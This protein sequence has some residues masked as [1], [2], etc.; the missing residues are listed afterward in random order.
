MK[1][2]RLLVCAV[3]FVMASAS[4]VIGQTSQGRILGTV[5][6][7][8]GAVVSS[9]IVTVTNTATGVSRKST[10]S[11]AGDFVVPELEA[12]PYSVKVQSKGFATIERTGVHL[13]VAKDVRVDVQL[14]PGTETEVMT[15]SGEAPIIDT[16]SDVLGE[17]FSNEAI[18]ELPLQG[19]DFQNLVI[20]Q[21]GIQREPGGGF[22]S[23][24]ANGNRPEENNFIIDGIDDNDAYYGTTVINAEGVEGTPATIL[25]IDAIQE[26]NIQSSPEADYGWKPGAI[27]NVGIKSGTNM[28]HGSTYYFNR[29]NADDARNWFNPVIA[30]DPEDSRVSAINLH[31]FG[32][33]AGGPI[34]KD[35]L[36]IFGNYEGIRSK[37]G[38]PL[39][40]VA[41][42]S[43]P[44]G[45]PST[46]IA[47]AM[48]EC[49]PNCS[50]ISVAL[51]AYL[52]YNPG[53]SPDMFTDF[54]NLN[55]GDN[56]IM[57]VDYTFSQK[58]SF[59]VDYFIGDSLQTEEDVTVLNPMFLSQAKTRAQV[60]G[61][62][63]LWAP[64]SRFTNQFHIGYNR[65]WQQVYVADHNLNPDSVGINTGV[66]NPTDFGL[67][68]IRVS[69]F[70]SHTVGGNGSWPLYTT[71]NQ[72]LQFT[73]NASYIRG[74]HYLRF[75]GEVRTGSTDNLRDTYGP[76]YARFDYSGP[77]NSPLENFVFGYPD[78][79]YVAVGDS[80]R[81]V[82]QTSVGGFIQD[83]WRMKPRFTLNLG[84]RYDVT[85]P[86]HERHDLLANFDPSVGMV[87]VGKQISSP[88]DTDY[89]NFAPRVGFAW[90]LFGDGKT[91]L[92]AGAGIIYEIPH[93]SVFIGQNNTEAQG[94]ALIPTGL[95]LTDINGNPLP[96][97]GTINA[98]TLSFAPGLTQLADNWQAGGP[99][100][101]N[102]S[103]SA[104][105]CSYD[106][107][108]DVYNPCP[109]FGVNHNIKTPYVTN[110]NLNLEHTL[111]QD[112]GITMAYVGTK[113]NRLYSIRDIN[114]NVYAND[115]LGDE[116][117]GRPY[118]N[119]F[120]YLSYIDMLGN[121]DNSIYH[122]LQV[123]L[124]QR[125]HKGLYFVSGYTWAHS[126]DD[127]SGNRQFNIQD[128]TN[129][130]AERGNSDHDIRHRFTIATTYQLPS[131]PGHGQMLQGW[132]LNT[133]FT[134]ETGEPLFFYDDGDDISGTGEFTDR[135]NFT[136][137]PSAVHWTKP[138]AEL[139][140]FAYD[141]TPGSTNPACDAVASQG[142]LQSYG[143]FAGNG[144]AMTPPEPGE[145]G[146]MRRNVVRGPAYVDWD[147]SVIKTFKFHERLHLEARAEF[148][149]I[150]N[151]PNFAGVDTDL[152][153]G[154]QPGG[155]TGQAQY[156][157]DIA[158]SNPVLGSG[159]ARHI[160]FGLKFIW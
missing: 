120:P 61:G 35:K 49:T 56:G 103:P 152:I 11:S 65:F 53:P 137:N 87:Q 8:S 14:K 67:P 51:A 129:P 124:K 26:F 9:A 66:T 17:T 36:F 127:S 37:V 141:G 44:I 128:S 39:Q 71:P 15:V 133:I 111:W 84:L 60:L 24:T 72:T 89:K 121:G 16:T 98:T 93:I 47:D 81:Y 149:D 90:D 40:V 22:L 156:T 113:G 2:F 104:V 18:N 151:H 69:G 112:A 29:N 160:Q 12:G 83:Q 73:D 7:P 150:L 78:Y 144:W 68:E 20:L 91:V 99:I 21:P 28:F 30:G 92:R 155:T 74:K 145:F 58:H 27:I 59:S 76:G 55:R 43:V 32:A 123:T 119:Q 101:G 126:I 77:E 82:S 31:Q 33:S 75:G 116:Q 136:G 48:A 142:Q 100:F 114:Q 41:P 153:D 23:I 57:K 34:M 5:T 154:Y 42:V 70:T 54:N 138:P 134:A 110:W 130:G 10:S 157:T 107:N 63:W 79:G 135:W 45:D 158:A 131:R 96:S 143:C 108:D 97:P 105:S 4:F 139:P 118:V 38:N 62:A 122:A 50:P 85:L 148:F 19:R 147:F 3:V 13:E 117:S 86:I 46:S 1:T 115:F 109:I 6:D 64:N 159:G 88:Y 106:P 52:P 132:G 95:T 25:P 140:F 94:L 102:L 125:T 146:N 80:H